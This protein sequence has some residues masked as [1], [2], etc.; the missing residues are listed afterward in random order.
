MLRRGHCRA[1]VLCCAAVFT[2]GVLSLSA[3]AVSRGSDGALDHGRA[4]ETPATAADGVLS[5]HPADCGGACEFSS[6]GSADLHAIEQRDDAVVH[7]LYLES[8]W[9]TARLR[10]LQAQGGSWR[11]TVTVRGPWRAGDRPVALDDWGSDMPGA[12]VAVHPAD[13]GTVRITVTASPQKI[14]AGRLYRTQVLLESG[15]NLDGDAW[16]YREDIGSVRP[17]RRGPEF[18]VEAS[19]APR[20]GMGG[21]CATCYV[22][23][24]IGGPRR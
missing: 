7:M 14:R 1:F 13:A 22:E 4:T 24:T 21:W 17:T 16:H 8:R 19:S 2:L 15:R 23:W 6:S 5:R 9:T 18:E 10:R 11:Q 20:P 3:L 12:R